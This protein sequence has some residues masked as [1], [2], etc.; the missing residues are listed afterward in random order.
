MSKSRQL[1]ILTTA[2]G[3]LAKGWVPYALYA[4]GNR[5]SDSAVCAN[6]AIFRACS[7]EEYYYAGSAIFEPIIHEIMALM[8]LMACNRY[9]SFNDFHNGM[10][11][12]GMR[13]V[14]I[15]NLLGQQAALEL[16][17]DAIRTLE[18]YIAHD[19]VESAMVIESKK[20]EEVTI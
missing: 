14:L 15:N 11:Y 3:H 5:F 2:R 10:D 17:D 18:T 7:L 12:S 13:H 9:P 6:G 1:E 16:F 20:E 19:L 8:N 4:D